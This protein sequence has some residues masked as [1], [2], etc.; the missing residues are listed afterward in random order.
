MLK[1][2]VQKLAT[3]NKGDLLYTL[4]KDTF[5]VYQVSSNEITKIFEYKD[6]YKVE[7]TPKETSSEEPPVKKNKNQ[8]NHQ[9][10]NLTNINWKT[11]SFK[12]FERLPM[13]WVCLCDF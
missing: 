4:V 6:T 12:I 13:W 3:N 5:Q 8:R 11:T 7:D 2:P 9:T 10:I 1:H